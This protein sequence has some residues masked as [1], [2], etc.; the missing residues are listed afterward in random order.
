MVGPDKY[1]VERL[2]ERPWL[3]VVLLCY[4]EDRVLE[5]IL[6][7]ARIDDSCQLKN[8]FSLFP[9]HT[10]CAD[11]YRINFSGPVHRF[12]QPLLEALIPRIH[13]LAVAG[14]PLK[15]ELP[16]LTLRSHFH[17]VYEKVVG[18]VNSRRPWG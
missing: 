13:L 9:V 4:R 18:H 14:Q 16:L 8:C 1:S 12:L 7:V 3:K 6:V 11:C 5:I 2:E 17:Q 10:H 15:D